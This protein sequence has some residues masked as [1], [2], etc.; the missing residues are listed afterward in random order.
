MLF[1]AKPKGQ[2]QPSGVGVANGSRHVPQ[3]VA[4]PSQVRQLMS[5]AWHETPL[6]K[7]PAG[8]TQTPLIKVAVGSAQVKHAE[9]L[10]GEVQVAHEGSQGS[11]VPFDD[12]TS[13]G[14]QMQVIPTRMAPGWQVVHMML[15][16][17]AA[18]VAQGSGQPKHTPGQGVSNPDSQAHRPLML[19]V[20][21]VGHW[22]LPGEPMRAATGSRHWVHLLGSFGAA[23]VAQVI[24]QDSQIPFTET[25]PGGQTHRPL[26]RIAFG[27]KQRVQLK[28]SLGRTQPRHPRAQGT[29]R[30]VVVFITKPG[31]HTHWPLTRVA[32]GSAQEVHANGSNANPQ[33]KH[34]G[35]QG[36][37]IWVSFKKAVPLG[38]TQSPATGIK[39]PGQAVQIVP[40]VA[41]HST[42]GG[43]QGIVHIPLLSRVNPGGQW[44]T[45]LENIALGS[46]QVKQAAGLLGRVQVAH[47]GAH[48]SHIPVNGLTAWPGH[49]QT[50]VPLTKV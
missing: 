6:K 48:R 15:P 40:L 28:A 5:Q 20:W 38:Q 16:G 24:S 45:P 35:S 26:H 13:G 3:L 18:Q 21:F 34:V 4:L 42:H 49:E 8:Q 12:S 19:N 41:R 9:A 17:T 30:P 25:V 1:R 29:Q 22:H 33:V 31:L 36:A 44:Q 39:S 27:S 2:T 37:Q 10:N 46:L 23:Q 32:L 47:S 43:V 14:T 7:V 50:Q 11:Q